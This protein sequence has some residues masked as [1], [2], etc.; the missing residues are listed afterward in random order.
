MKELLTQAGHY[1]IGLATIGAASGLAATGSIG[2]NLAMDTIIGV[3]SLLI[4]GALGAT[5]P[6]PKV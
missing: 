5:V 6:T 1:V 2:G 3:A 4:G